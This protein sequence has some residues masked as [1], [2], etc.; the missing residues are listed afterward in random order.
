MMQTERLPVAK[1][2]SGRVRLSP[3]LNWHE[4][5]NTVLQLM[6]CLRRGRR[7]RPLAARTATAEHHVGLLERV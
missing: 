4:Q 1:Y 2:I 3:D 7:C 5:H 6:A